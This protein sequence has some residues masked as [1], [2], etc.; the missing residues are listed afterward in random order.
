MREQVPAEQQAAEAQR[1]L[2]TAERLQMREQE[3]PVMPEEQWE[4]I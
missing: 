2:R 1:L 3:R 4:A